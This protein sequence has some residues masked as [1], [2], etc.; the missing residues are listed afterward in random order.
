MLGLI[1]P[2]GAGKTTAF[3]LITGFDRPTLGRIFFDGVDVTGEVAHQRAR[4][5][6][7]RTFQAH[8]TFKAVSVLRNVEIALSASRRLNSRSAITGRARELLEI[9]GITHFADQEAGSLPHAAAGLLGVAMAMACQP[10]LVLLDEPLAGANRTEADEILH[11]VQ[12]VRRAGTT[13]VLVEHNMQAVMAHCE[14]ILVLHH[15]HLLAQGT[16]DEIQ[17]DRLVIEA[18][19][20]T[21]EDDHAA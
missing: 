5:G 18:Y 9:I 19:L 21:D 1:G 11:A 16:P 7:V 8:D 2:N 20:G 10:K 13:V 15:G 17:N 12:E 4:R 6:M 14:R 3:N